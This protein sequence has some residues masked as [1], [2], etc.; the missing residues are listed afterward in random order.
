MIKNWAGVIGK[1]VVLCFIVLSLHCTKSLS[2][3][4]GWLS[5]CIWL[6]FL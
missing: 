1:G 6:A 2:E 4:A 5:E 3:Y